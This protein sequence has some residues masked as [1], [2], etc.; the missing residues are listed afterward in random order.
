M[1]ILWPYL[2]RPFGVVYQVWKGT[3]SQ[4]SIIG[5]PDKYQE[6]ASSTMS[7]L[8]PCKKKH[9]VTESVPTVHLGHDLNC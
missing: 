6:I 7:R 9:G 8:Q 2:N 5:K 1:Y 4:L 3:A